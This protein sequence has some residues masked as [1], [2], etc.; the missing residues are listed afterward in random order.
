MYVTP[1]APS[2]LAGAA[3]IVVDIL[4]ATSVHDALIAGGVDRVY[5]VASFPAGIELRSELAGAKLIGE[6][7]ALPPPEANYGNS[8]TEFA[9]LDVEGWTVVHVTSN[10]TRALLGAGEAMQVLS[11]CLRN[12]SASV[13]RT[14]KQEAARVA[15]V[16]SGDYGG[17]APSIEDTFAAGAYVWAFRQRNAALDLRGGARLALKLYEAYGGDPLAAFADS[18]HAEH[19]RKLKFDAD[20]TYAAAIDAS[21]SIALLEQDDLGRPYLRRG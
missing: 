5:P 10:G 18:P 17:T 19:L 14:L 16:C 1:P 20:L 8:P 11:G 7:G 4:R 9:G 2:V 21:A 6:I 12:V 13:E 15:I 3:V